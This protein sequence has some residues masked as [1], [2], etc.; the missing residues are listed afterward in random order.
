MDA[1]RW[2]KLEK[3]FN[4]TLELPVEERSAFL[5]SACS[6]DAVL[7]AEIDSLL[8]E[9]SDPET[10]LSESHFTVG[11]NLLSE[12][13]TELP[14]VTLGN[15]TV[16]RKIARGGMGEIFLARDERLGRRVAI[17]L[18]PERLLAEADSVNRF[19]HEARAA[20]AISHPNVAQVYEIGESSDRIY[21]VME[22]VSGMTLRE[23]LS[24]PLTL[25][26]AINIIIQV[27]LG[28]SAAHAQGIIHRD[29]K[30]EN[31]MIRPDG[32]VKVVDFGLAKFAVP[33]RTAVAEGNR[34]TQI[35]RRLTQ[36]VHTEPG[37]LMGTASYMSPEQARGSE[38]DLR[39]DIWS[40]G[41]VF[42][43]M[44]AG[45]PPFQ[46]ATNSDVI[47]E[48][49]KSEPVFDHSFDRLPESLGKL[50]RR[51][52]SKERSSRYPDM[53]SLI[54][55]LYNIRTDVE[56]QKLTDVV[57]GRAG[58]TQ[59]VS[60][61]P[62]R[63][64]RYFLIAAVIVL[65][66]AGSIFLV[67]D[68]R[69]SRTPRPN[70][71]ITHLTNDGK[72]MDA[73]I[74]PDGQLIAYV[75]IRSGRQ[76]LR[77]RNLQTNEDWELLPPDPGLI[78]G[79][80]FAL[81]NQ[82]VFYVSKQPGSTVSV[83]YRLPLRGGVSQ[84]LIVNIDSPPGL[85]PD[86][87]QLA[88]V[89][90]YP[91]QHR[92]AIIVANI[93]GSSEQEVFSRQHPERLALSGISWSPDGKIIAAGASRHDDTEAAVLG[94]PIKGGEA[95]EITPWSWS[96]IRG[97]VW[98]ND[99][100]NIL[101]SAH[102]PNNNALQVWRVAYPEKTVVPVTT[103]NNQYEE[104]TL[105]ANMLVATQTYE[106]ADLWSADALHQLTTDGHNGADGI[107]V[108]RNKVVF[109]V[110][111][112]SSSQLWT[113]NLDGNERKLLTQN[114]GVHPAATKENDLIAYVSLEGGAHHIWLVD[115]DGRNNHQLTSGAGENYPSFSSDGKWIYYVSRAQNRGTLWKI[116][117]GGGT[118]VQVTSTGIIMNPVISPDGQKFAC[119]YRADEADRWKI[120]VFKIDAS[121]P[122][123]TLALPSAFH[124]VIRWTPDG[125]ALTYLDK[126]NGAQNIW[127]QPLDGS[128]A[129]QL[130]NFT[131]DS[132]LHYDLSSE[133]QFIASRGGRRRDI[134]LMKNLN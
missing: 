27:S 18:L 36:V 14:S 26:E 114:Y 64:W 6:D 90:S 21:T 47:A 119:T 17:K 128:P 42:Y 110:G 63:K 94:V 25:G 91:G 33:A 85:S 16:I 108:T 131:D 122:S 34:D 132:I 71:Q 99:G 44:I 57:V 66:M 2:Q 127:K 60:V 49:L 13:A 35:G 30:P 93:D 78:W 73:A 55:D 69:T 121:T 103:D 39:T 83:L 84:K 10:F 38:T 19:R 50:L 54:D 46:G 24:R 15:Y 105:A 52:L 51:V 80:R 45:S 41:V 20:S 81:N 107:C 98:Q 68:L 109:T 79:M 124:Q 31:I 104:A 102:L 5:D 113:M 126:Q 134:V 86:N 116:Q 29:I 48:I 133:H 88:F 67:R 37:L 32:L 111:E 7:R 28:V 115:S 75:P 118:P 74:S 9:A 101:F 72:V 70:L 22:F 12:Q 40:W 117:T 92:D 8:S 106:V 77:V 58:A 11:A 82:S 89:R 96:S 43:E 112:Y 1:V 123:Q 61:K 59:A 23:R 65:L 120:A 97:V 3:I 4:A 56:T 76:S 53:R 125:L 129:V 62:T 130:T 100:H 87:M 95:F